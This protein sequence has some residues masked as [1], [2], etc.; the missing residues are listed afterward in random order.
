MSQQASKPASR[1]RALPSE[2]GRFLREQARRQ[3]RARVEAATLHEHDNTE[4]LDGPRLGQS[5]IAE[6]RRL[7][8]RHK[9]RVRAC[10]VSSTGV[11]GWLWRRE[12]GE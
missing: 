8:G 5:E 1:L 11:A 10:R 12:R 9:R 3:A 2:P 4:P 7:D 6:E